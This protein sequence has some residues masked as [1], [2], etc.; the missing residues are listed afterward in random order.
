MVY[1]KPHPF[2]ELNGVRKAG[3]VVERSLIDP[4]RMDVEQPRVAGGTEASIAA[5]PASAREGTT[6]SRIAAATASS[7][8]SRAR[9]RMKTESCMEGS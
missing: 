9:K 1:Q 2:D 3:V 4:A 5:Q 8:P 7:L 6:T